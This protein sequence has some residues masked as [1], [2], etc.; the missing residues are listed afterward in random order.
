MYKVNYSGRMSYVSN[1]FY[2]HI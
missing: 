2:C 1:H